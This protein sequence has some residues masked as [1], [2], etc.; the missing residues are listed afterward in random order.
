MSIESK[1]MEQKIYH[2]IDLEK[3]ELA[4]QEIRKYLSQE[5][6]DDHAHAMLAFCLIRLKKNDQA[7]KEANTAISL[8]PDEPHNHY[9]QGLIYYAT[10]ENKKALDSAD[11]AIRLYPEECEYYHL[12]SLV[13]LSMSQW[14]KA[15]DAAM[16][17][18]SLDPTDSGCM[19][20]R[21]LALTQLG[22]HDEARSGIAE[23]LKENPEDERTHA[24]LGWSYLHQKKYDKALE[25][26]REALRIEP[27]FE[28]ARQGMLNALKARYLLFRLML[29]FFIW[30]S[31]LPPKAQT[32]LIIGAYILMKVI[33]SLSGQYPEIQ[34]FTAPL[35]FVYLFFVLMTWIANPL[36]NMLLRFNKYGRYALSDSEKSASNWLA[37]LLGGGLVMVI[38]GAF[39]PTDHLLLTGTFLL[40]LILPVVRLFG[41]TGMRR[42][43]TVIAASIISICGITAFTALLLGN[44]PVSTGGFVA[45]MIT[46]LI[47]TWV[48]SLSSIHS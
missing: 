45:G 16:K 41:S 27:D 18:L 44:E 3:F 43:V 30:M 46:L 15:L 13:Y 25:H 40:L 5:P 47:F 48:Y 37:F 7:I 42:K 33:R 19:N 21:S 12:K 14:Q 34:P 1:I 36:F 6:N 28:W 31:T 29:Q 8:E 24:N 10:N 4:E 2:L 22:R 20:S 11:E 35:L 26:F 38:C 9:I 23:A 32:G 39:M 17:G